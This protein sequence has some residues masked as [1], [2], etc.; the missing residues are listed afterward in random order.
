MRSDTHTD[1]KCWTVRS[2][3]DR[4]GPYSLTRRYRRQVPAAAATPAGDLHQ[5]RLP[6]IDLQLAVP[7]QTFPGATRQHPLPH[8]KRVHAQ[9]SAT[10]VAHHPQ[11]G[12]DP[13]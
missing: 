4:K 8:G 3:H 1:I 2:I 9:S 6:P 10:V 5:R 7:H 11:R 12:R 13:R